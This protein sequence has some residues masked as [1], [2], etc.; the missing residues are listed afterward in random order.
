MFRGVYQAAHIDAAKRAIEQ[1]AFE[2]GVR[3]GM[4]RQKELD[5]ATVDGVIYISELE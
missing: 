5:A 3:E 4:R 2:R 1:E